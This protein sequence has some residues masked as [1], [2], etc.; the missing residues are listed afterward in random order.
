MC[1]GK[2]FQGKQSEREIVMSLKAPRVLLY[3]FLEQFDGLSIA[4][5]LRKFYTGLEQRIK[6]VL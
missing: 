4:F 1:F 2:T 5:L 3:T 6:G